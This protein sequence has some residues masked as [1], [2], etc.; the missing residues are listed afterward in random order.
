[1]GKATLKPVSAYNKDLDK[2]AEGYF[3]RETGEPVSSEDLK[4]YQEALAQYHLH[5]EA[6]FD[7]GDYLDSGVT[8]RR[9]IVATVPEHIGKEANRWEE[10]FYLG[11]DLDAQ[12]KYGI[13][14]E[15]HKRAVEI[16]RQA[17]K[18]FGQRKLAKAADV[19]LSEVS[20][21]LLSKH[22]PT[23]A[24]LAKLCQAVARLEREA[25]QEAREV[26][27]VVDAAKKRC[28]EM[29]L[30]GF[31]RQARVDA[32]NLVSVFQNRRKPSQRMLMKVRRALG[33]P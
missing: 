3:D 9:H 24:T 33:Q 5:P 31:A 13:S 32:A 30:R 16:V 6:K 22:D 20:A 11:L 27:E 1:M 10:Q 19:S 21:I 2:A 12:T 4:S 28:Q 14:P 7:N 15:D 26:Q 23:S 17:E 18:R 25:L 8:G 29:G